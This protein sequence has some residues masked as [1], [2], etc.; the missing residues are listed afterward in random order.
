MGLRD[1]Y[2]GAFDTAEAVRTYIVKSGDTL[3]KIAKEQLGD[4]IAFLDIFKANC[5]RL[6]YAGM[7]T[8]GQVL[9]IPHPSQR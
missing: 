9:K 2:A 5:D 7:V 3:S 1:K 8:P 4:P 6:S